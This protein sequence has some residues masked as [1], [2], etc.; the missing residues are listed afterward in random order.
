MTRETKIGLLVGL[1]FIILF[2]I[3]LSEAG[4]RRRAIVAPQ[5]GPL[6]D[7]QTDY[8]QPAPSVMPGPFEPDGDLAAPEPV[9]AVAEPVAAPS[10]AR[11]EPAATDGSDRAS[12]S[13]EPA[14]DN[15]PSPEF[16]AYVVRKNDNL[17]KIAKHML[18]TDS[19][20]AVEAIYAANRDRL[21]SRDRLRVGQELKIPMSPKR[22]ELSPA[23]GFAG[24]MVHA[25]QSVALTARAEPKYRWYQVRRGD[26][27]SSIARRELGDERRWPELYELN[28]KAF[29][30]PHR[31]R[32]GVRVKLPAKGGADRVAAVAEALRGRAVTQ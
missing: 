5:Y 16:V 10:A 15:T 7:S 2:G 32:P 24:A 20:E 8:A 27:W 30:N 28:R 31:L 23:P 17:T 3:I 11:Q 9:L 1:G 12:P 13:A 26:T 19:R 21:V 22:A 4:S 18:R 6:A 29:P 25:E 14:A